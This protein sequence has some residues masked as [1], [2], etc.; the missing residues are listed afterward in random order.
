MVGS[1]VQHKDSRTVM[2]KNGQTKSTALSVDHKPQDPE[3]KKRIEECGGE[4]L[5]LEGDVSRLPT[6]SLGNLRGKGPVRTPRAKKG[7]RP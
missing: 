7:G 1:P 3:E 5:R 2:V 4:V 6:S